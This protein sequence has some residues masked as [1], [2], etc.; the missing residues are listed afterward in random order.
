MDCRT[1]KENFD[2]GQEQAGEFAEHLVGCAQCTAWKGQMLEVLHMAADLPQYD[3]PLALTGQIMAAVEREQPAAAA[4]LAGQ[5]YLVPLA[6]AGAACLMVL[7]LESVDGA[8]SWI[9]GAAGLVAFYLMLKGAARQS[10]AARQF[11]TGNELFKRRRK[12]SRR[13]D[14]Q[15]AARWRYFETINQT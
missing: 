14:L 1:F 2:I 6:V 13:G 12:F 10:Q 9:I 15:P 4:K 8:I 11:Q 7:P 5:G 3:V